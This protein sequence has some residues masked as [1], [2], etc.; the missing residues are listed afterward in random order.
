MIHADA[1]L[2]LND[3]L[4]IHHD[5]HLPRLLPGPPSCHERSDEAYGG[6]RASEGRTEGGVPMR[7]WVV[8]ANRCIAFDGGSPDSSGHE[9][10]EDR[11]FHSCVFF[12]D[13]DSWF[14]AEYGH[15]CRAVEQLTEGGRRHSVRR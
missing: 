10:M 4:W 11:S 3:S 12:S 15:F 5:V 7:D 8:S 6:E 1:S 2:V 14:V 9:R 13:W